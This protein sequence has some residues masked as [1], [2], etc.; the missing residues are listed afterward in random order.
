[1]NTT[2]LLKSF[3]HFRIAQRDYRQGRLRVVS[4]QK[5]DVS[6]TG[7]NKIQERKIHISRDGLIVKN[8]GLKIGWSDNNSVCIQAWYDIDTCLFNYKII[9]YRYTTQI[10]EQVY[11][12]VDAWGVLGIN[13]N[14]INRHSKPPINQDN[15]NEYKKCVIMRIRKE[16][17]YWYRDDIEYDDMIEIHNKYEWK[18]DWDRYNRHVFISK[19]CTKEHEDLD[20]VIREI[21]GLN[22]GWLYYNKLIKGL[23][24]FQMNFNMVE[25]EIKDIN[26]KTQKREKIRISLDVFIR[27]Q[28]GTQTWIVSNILKPAREHYLSL[29][30]DNEEKKANTI[31][32]I[33]MILNTSDKIEDAIRIGAIDMIYGL[34]EDKEYFNYIEFT[35]N[36]ELIEEFISSYGAVEKIFNHLMIQIPI[37]RG[38][39]QYEDRETCY[40]SSKKYSVAKVKWWENCMKGQSIMRD[41]DFKVHNS[42]FQSKSFC[43]NLKHTQVGA[44][45]FDTKNSI[46]TSSLLKNINEKYYVRTKY[47]YMNK[48]S[49]IDLI[50]RYEEDGKSINKVA[51]SIRINAGVYEFETF[52]KENNSVLLIIGRMYSTNEDNNGGLNQPKRIVF[53]L[54]IKDM[55]E[56]Y[57][58]SLVITK[59]SKDELLKVLYEYSI[60]QYQQDDD[61]IDPDT[62]VTI[63]SNKII[64][65]I[66]DYQFT[67]D[68]NT[69]TIT[70]HEVRVVDFDLSKAESIERFTM[71]N[72][73]SKLFI[74]EEKHMRSMVMNRD[75]SQEVL[76]YEC[77]LPD[78]ILSSR[79][80]MVVTLDDTYKTRDKG[81][82][83]KKRIVLYE[84]R[85]QDIVVVDRMST[86][87]YLENSISTVN[88][89]VIG[90]KDNI[91]ILW[92][93]ADYSL[94][95]IVSL[96]GKRLVSSHRYRRIHIKSMYSELKNMY[97]NKMYIDYDTNDVRAV[98]T[99][100]NDN[101]SD[102]MYDDSKEYVCIVKLK[103]S[104]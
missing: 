60:L 44:E 47:D 1:M 17:I 13:N 39:N 86:Q 3:T 82:M 75:G 54:D 45:V 78:S 93:T 6:D 77:T 35:R 98:F 56:R 100:Y 97:I 90:E 42:E 94:Y 91:Y 84:I 51:D 48:H 38:H 41:L 87:F 24:C 23:E 103:I 5:V 81:V 16:V 32:V 64:L 62:C 101:T 31:R 59:E 55:I 37:I 36:N 9:V 22:K 57:E 26:T 68:Y 27:S 95:S 52:F 12:S 74:P 67:D 65:I 83:G 8:D 11:T 96:H 89:Y 104:L 53:K 40:Y 43:I 92:I 72:D 79:N 85:K 50:V 61:K 30:S 46:S 102:M 88:N 7:N 28:L 15:L 63:S 10:R 99:N 80:M 18:E 49:S 21:V 19:V 58:D 4:M 20:S 76:T 25:R 73:I 14:N 71:K 34:L 69:T 2:H 33:D 66:Y 70:Y 29:P